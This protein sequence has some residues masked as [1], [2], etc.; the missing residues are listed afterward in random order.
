MPALA[1][2]ALLRA[3]K[4]GDPDLV[5]Y[6][7]GE[8]DVLKDEAVR[9][10]V[11]RAVEPALR[12]FNVDQRA[13]GDMDA[14]ALHAVLN[15][16]PMLAE[17]RA[18]VLRGV[19]QLRKKSKP[20]DALL[21]YLEEPSSSTL[22]VLVQGDAEA[23][24]ADLAARATTVATERLPTERA[25]RW[26]GHA[27]SMR[28]VVVEPAAAELLVAAVGADLGALRQELEKLAVVVQGR[29]V[30]PGDV[31]ALV[32]VRHGETLQDLVDAALAREP[33]R[34][35][36][37]VERVL[38]QSGMTGVRMVSALGTALVGVALARAELDRGTPRARLADT[39]FRRL[40]ASRPF[41]LRSYKIEA[42]RWAEWGERWRGPELRSAL[43]LALVTDRTLKSSGVSEE[44]G[45]IR[46][47]VLSL[48][49]PAREV[50]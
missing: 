6:L 15:T 34:A 19:E 5:Y 21:A 40:L 2:D 11:D 14:E 31:S 9:A 48:A 39:L 35:A 41:G 43:R 18:V 27:A 47:L 7:H 45:L 24:E 25:V 20:R 28:G 1:F 37:L 50:A 10:L 13:A 29:P 26:V 4:R 3:L 33:A 32:G 36:Q 49:V 22:L 16:P 17:R 46:Q 38:A 8:E 23:P 12:D 44:G 30:A 42:A